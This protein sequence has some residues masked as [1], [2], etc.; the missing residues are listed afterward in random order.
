MSTRYLQGRR[1]RHQPI[2]QQ[3]V[4]SLITAGDVEILAKPVR[5]GLVHQF[6][7]L[8]LVKDAADRTRLRVKLHPIVRT[9]KL[10]SGIDFRRRGICRS[11]AQLGPLPTPGRGNIRCDK[12]YVPQRMT[13]L[14]CLN[15]DSLTRHGIHNL[16]AVIQ[17]AEDC[18][19][20]LP[21]QRVEDDQTAATG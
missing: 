9:F 19:A 4:R 21:V 12:A 15:G 1:Q 6:A 8:L 14:H 16:I 7:L 2:L 20:A 18:S 11:A 3:S 17:I 5:A 10:R 13:I